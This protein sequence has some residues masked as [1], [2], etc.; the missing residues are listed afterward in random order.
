MINANLNTILQTIQARDSRDLTQDD[1]NKMLL[2]II[3][4]ALGEENGA[5]G[6]EVAL[7]AVAKLSEGIEDVSLNQTDED[8]KERLPLEVLKLVEG[9]R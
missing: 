7:K 6:L 8:I 1:I 9:R 2:E 4:K 5:K 3:D